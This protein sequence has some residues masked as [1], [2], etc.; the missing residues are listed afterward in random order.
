M[1]VATSCKSSAAAS[2][3]RK[4]FKNVTARR[5]FWHVDSPSSATQNHGLG[6]LPRYEKNVFLKIC[7]HSNYY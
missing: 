3:E 7:K 1:T 4:S 6:V 5:H 2:V